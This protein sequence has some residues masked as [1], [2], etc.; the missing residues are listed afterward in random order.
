MGRINAGSMSVTFVALLVITMPM[1]AQENEHNEH[2][3]KS[4]PKT[5]YATGTKEKGGIWAKCADGVWEAHIPRF[6]DDEEGKVN[7]NRFGSTFAGAGGFIN[8][9]QN[10]KAVYFLGTFPPLEGR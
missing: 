4:A 8:I 9:S 6:V 10:A 1:L 5:C 2:K 3:E 7:V